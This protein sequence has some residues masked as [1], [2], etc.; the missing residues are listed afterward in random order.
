MG[1]PSLRWGPA[2]FRKKT[3]GAGHACACG[4]HVQPTLALS[5]PR[6]EPQETVRVGMSG[7]VIREGYTRSLVGDQP[8][9]ADVLRRVI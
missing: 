5:L 2:L 7:F 3:A 1:G 9:G 4:L 6:R 8:A